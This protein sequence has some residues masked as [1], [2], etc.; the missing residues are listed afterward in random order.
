MCCNQIVSG[1]NLFPHNSNIYLLINA[2]LLK[3]DCLG[4]YTVSWMNT[5]PLKAFYKVHCLKLSKCVLKF[6]SANGNIIKSFS[7]KCQLEFWR[8]KLVTWCLRLVSVRVWNSSF[9]WQ[10]MFQVFSIFS[11]GHADFELLEITQELV[12]PIFYSKGYFQ[13]FERF[14]IIFHNL[15]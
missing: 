3:V 14:L 4:P 8:K 1:L 5:P 6:G 9:A 12:L 2:V 11:R 15:V 13:H 10:W 7:F